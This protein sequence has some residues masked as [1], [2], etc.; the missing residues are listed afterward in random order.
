MNLNKKWQC[1]WTEIWKSNVFVIDLV[2]L[3][4][5]PKCVFGPNPAGVRQGCVVFAVPFNIAIDWEE[6]NGRTNTRDMMGIILIPRGYRL[7]RWCSSHVPYMTR[8]TRLTGKDTKTH[9]HQPEI[10]N[11]DK[12]KEIQGDGNKPEKPIS[13]IYWYRSWTF[14]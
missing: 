7:C 13:L 9:W 14:I 8:V 11:K 4:L 2:K 5:L 1:I 3:Y 10:R 6:N 12:K